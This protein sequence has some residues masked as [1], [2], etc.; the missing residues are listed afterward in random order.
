[1]HTTLHLLV[2]RLHGNLRLIYFIAQKQRQSETI[3][4]PISTR[5][6]YKLSNY[7]VGLMD[8]QCDSSYQRLVYLILVSYSLEKLPLHRTIY[9]KVYTKNRF[10]FAP[11][12]EIYYFRNNI[13][14]QKLLTNLFLLTTTKTM[15]KVT[16]NYHM[17]PHIASLQINKEQYCT[18]TLF[19]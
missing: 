6:F 16:I 10:T 3:K 15:V 4:R 17:H 8:D 9:V 19:P 7:F 12:P 5:T 13:H 1:M 2:A 14:E 11:C 18:I